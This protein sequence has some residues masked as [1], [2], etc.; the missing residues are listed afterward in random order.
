M[1]PHWIPKLDHLREAYHY[2]PHHFTDDEKVPKE[3]QKDLH[4]TL[5][6]VMSSKRRTSTLDLRESFK[7]FQSIRFR[8]QVPLPLQM[9]R[10]DIDNERR[11][12]GKLRKCMNLSQFVETRSK[13][14]KDTERELERTLKRLN[15]VKRKCKRENQYLV[16][17]MK[18]MRTNYTKRRDEISR[19]KKA[20]LDCEK[21]ANK[22]T[23]IVIRA[24]QNAR[25]DMMRA[26][27]PK[28]H[29]EVQ[30]CLENEQK[31]REERSRT[32][33]EVNERVSRAL[34]S[35]FQKVVFETDYN[36]PETRVNEMKSQR[37]QLLSNCCE[38][39]ISRVENLNHVE[40]EK[41]SLSFLT[42]KETNRIVRLHETLQM[43]SDQC[44][45]FWEVRR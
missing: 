38:E 4:E 7:R 12:S 34:A 15:E 42:S 24:T 3:L 32:I 26:I 2:H 40:E 27:V 9:I 5:K 19:A 1:I 29:E 37:V 21:K 30:F 13:D 8:S 16:T 44:C 11:R 31:M 6:G 39:L 35:E 17:K 20:L 10:R 23:D 28:I 33:R 36:I 45:L 43:S 22:D 18:L 41:T 14:V 25:D